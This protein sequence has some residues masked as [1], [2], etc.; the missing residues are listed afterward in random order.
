MCK[1]GIIWELIR[2]LSNLVCEVIV[3]NTSKPF[4]L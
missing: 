1:N 2:R 4:L 3:L